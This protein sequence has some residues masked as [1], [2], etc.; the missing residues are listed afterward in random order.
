MFN[1]AR[2]DASRFAEMYDFGYKWLGMYP[3]KTEEEFKE[4][5]EDGQDLYKLYDDNTEAL[6]EGEP[7]EKLTEEDIM[8]GLDISEILYFKSELGDMISK[9][10]FI[11]YL[12]ANEYNKEKLFNEIATWLE[13]KCRTILGLD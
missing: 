6:I 9:S 8:I 12:N 4:L 13:K 2:M 3:I 7:Y 1:F 11:D 10:G 5:I